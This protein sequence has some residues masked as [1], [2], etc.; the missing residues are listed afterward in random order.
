MLQ[1]NVQNM[2][3]EGV[4]P[5]VGGVGWLGELIGVFLVGGIWR[6]SGVCA[7]FTKMRL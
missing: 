1:E 6:G 3:Q 2:L 7:I 4:L 5:L